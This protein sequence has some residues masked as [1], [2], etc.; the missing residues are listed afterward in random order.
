MALPWSCLCPQGGEQLCSAIGNTQFIHKLYCNSRRILN[1]SFLLLSAWKLGERREFSFCPCH[2]VEWT[3]ILLKEHGSLGEAGR[4]L[5]FSWGRF[6]HPF[7][8]GGGGCLFFF[9]LRNL[10]HFQELKRWLYCYK[11]KA[12]AFSGLHSSAT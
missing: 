3:F 8:L 10:I 12:I 6:S 4:A 7:Y 5:L 9:F 2:R 1:R 11:T